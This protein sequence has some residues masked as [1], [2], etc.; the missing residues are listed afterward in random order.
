MKGV[1]WVVRGGFLLLALVVLPGSAM[2]AKSDLTGR[3]T[4]EGDLTAGTLLHVDLRL[5]HAKGWQHIEGIEVSLALHGGT[6]E[7]L[8]IFPTQ[9]S[10]AI[11]GAGAPASLGQSTEVRGDYFAVNPAQVSLAARGRS[12]RLIIP[13]R[14]RVEPPTGARL[15]FSASAVPV[16]SLG[17]KALTPPVESNSGFSWGTL[18]LAIAVALF[19]GGF[20]GNVFA[21]RRRPPKGPSVYA[22]VARKLAEERTEATTS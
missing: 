2:A 17:P 10:L 6:L 3:G 15:E 1:K 20:L 14:L 18:G 16:A 21:G 8:Q 22:A 11:V 13:I 19:A 5:Q 4:V 7:R 9:S 12:I